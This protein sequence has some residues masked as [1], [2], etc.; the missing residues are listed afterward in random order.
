LATGSIPTSFRVMNTIA[1]KLRNPAPLELLELFALT[2]SPY[3]MRYPYPK[4]ESHNYYS[5]TC[6]VPE[7]YVEPVAAGLVVDHFSSF[8]ASMAALTRAVNESIHC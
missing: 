2:L 3:R 1:S 6:K 4:F 7:Q 5:L 8:C